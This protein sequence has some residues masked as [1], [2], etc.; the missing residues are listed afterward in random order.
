M[1]GTCKR[2]ASLM[3]L[4][5][6]TFVLAGTTVARADATQMPDATAHAQQIQTCQKNMQAQSSQ[7]GQKMTNAALQLQGMFGAI[8]VK[9]QYCWPKIK[10]LFDSIG[11]LSSLRS[12]PFQ[13]IVNVIMGQIASQIL[14]LINNACSAALSTIQSFKNFLLSQ[15]NHLCIPL[16]DLNLGLGG[17]A[18]LSFSNAPAC[19]PG[20]IPAFQFQYGP[21]TGYSTPAAPNYQLFR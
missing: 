3:A 10:A 2:F 16:P 9:A 17:I 7:R 13:A 18:G 1:F 15:M 11:Q 21:P 8:D 6:L 5:V 12:N 14:A 4:A 20:S 19:G